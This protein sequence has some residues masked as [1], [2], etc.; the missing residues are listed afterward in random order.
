MEPSML[1]AG[2]IPTA[3]LAVLVDFAVGQCQ[4]WLIPARRKPSREGGIN[5]HR[6]RRDFDM[7]K[8]TFLGLAAAAAMT[9]AG[10]ALAQTLVVGARISPNSS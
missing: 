8:R 9:L 10:P 4:Y 6:N 2:A 7:L 1:L 3:L 5:H